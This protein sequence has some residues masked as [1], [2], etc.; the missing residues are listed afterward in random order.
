MILF[1]IFFQNFSNKNKYSQKNSKSLKSVFF[2][3][4][5]KEKRTSRNL[6]S[7][8]HDFDDRPPQSCP[9]HLD[10]SHLKSLFSNHLNSLVRVGGHAGTLAA[11]L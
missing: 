11:Q 7:V 6:Q 5:R 3:V 8:A 10:P 9:P 1:N 2:I 4:F